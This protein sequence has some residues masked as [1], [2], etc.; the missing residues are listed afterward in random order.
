[1]TNVLLFPARNANLVRGVAGLPGIAVSPAN[2]LDELRQG[3]ASA[4]VLLT[5]NRVYEA[6]AARIIRDLGR[7]L[8]WIQFTT[9]GIDK[10]IANG[11]PEGI[12]VTNAAGFHARRVAEHATMLLLSVARRQFET[13]A[14]RLRQE[15]IRDDVAPRVM[16]LERRTLVIVGLG[17]IGQQVARKA[18]AFDM[19][20]IG[21]SR[22][23]APLEH[24]DDVRPRVELLR[25]LAEADALVLTASYDASTHHIIDARAIAAMKPAAVLVNVARGLLIDE[26]AMIEA[27]KAN[28]LAAAGLDVMQT[29]PLPAGHVL[30]TLPN[31]I[32]TPHIAGAGGDSTD[33]IV[34]IFS[35]NYARFVAGQPL[36][37]LVYGPSTA[38][39]Q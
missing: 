36:A 29:E 32:V 37:K 16:S 22:E 1:M 17:A 11:L 9:S 38:R 39:A 21:I 25:S 35:G 23:T 34:E 19:R 30:W 8:R 24:F 2:T 7:R 15:W 3:L 33:A 6:E 4:D 5:S 12:P 26:A 31:V 13:A 18:K 20:V 14:A 10:A 28:R 27:L